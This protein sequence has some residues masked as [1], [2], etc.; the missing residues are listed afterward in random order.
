MLR[1]PWVNHRNA[2]YATVLVRVHLCE[3]G[4]AEHARAG[5]LG[6]S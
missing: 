1:M 5:G 4:V 6:Q 3:S 2:A